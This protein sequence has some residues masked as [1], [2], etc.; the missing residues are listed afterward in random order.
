MIH[1]KTSLFRAGALASVL[2]AVL[3]AGCADVVPPEAEAPDPFPSFEE[4]RARTHPDSEGRFVVDGDI[5]VYS[6][7][8]LREFY[9][10]IL[11]NHLDAVAAR[12]GLGVARE[13][14]L[15][16][17]VSGVDDLQSRADRFDITYCVSASFGSN[18]NAVVDGLAAATRSWS[19][20]LG[21]RYRYV[22]MSVC[23]NAAAVDFDVRPAPGLVIYNANAFYPH[24]PR[25]IRELLIADS[26]FT[27]TEGGRDLQGIL[28]H[29]LGHTLGFR[30][31][32]LLVLPTCTDEVASDLRV[33]TDYDVNSVMHYVQCRPTKT[34]GY[35]QSYLDY[36]GGNLLY[37][38]APALTNAAA[39]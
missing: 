14:L 6:E 37:G 3:A 28:R 2:L 7:Q 5:A 33:V 27:T 19:D 23:D 22:S 32:H 13:H 35:R 29:E 10:R 16:N 30:H 20:I 21:V 15:V 31:E 36:R 11:D 18:F 9:Q 1:S 24:D 38:L 8:G 26:A 4:F 12:D 39:L 34:G 17:Q 25:N